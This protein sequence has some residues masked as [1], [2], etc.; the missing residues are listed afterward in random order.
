VVAVVV[1][2]RGA[3]RAPQAS[4][5]AHC[6]LTLDLTLTAAPSLSPYPEP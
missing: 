1:V 5:L 2:V 6:T 4:I 3:R